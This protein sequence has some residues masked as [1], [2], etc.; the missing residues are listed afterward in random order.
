MNQLTIDDA[1]AA[2]HD[3]AARALEKAQRADSAFADRAKA[4]ILEHLKNFGPTS[5]E[6]LTQAC[7]D[8]GIVPAN[9]DRAFGGIFFSL[10]HPKNSRIRCLRSDLPRRFGHG[11]SGGRLWGLVQ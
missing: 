10:S 1:I 7:K 4:F 5:G 9:D 3:C 6:D 2:G 11:T 8:A